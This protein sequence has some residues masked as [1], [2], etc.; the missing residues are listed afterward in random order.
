MGR[1]RGRTALRALLNE[2]PSDKRVLQQRALLAEME[3]ALAE[4]NTAQ[5]N[6]IAMKLAAIAKEIRAAEDEQRAAMSAAVDRALSLTD[7]AVRGAKL[8]E[9]FEICA[10]TEVVAHDDF[11]DD[12]TVARAIELKHAIVAALDAMPAGRAVLEALLD[13][14]FAGVRASAGAYRLNASL[15]RERIVPLLQEIERRVM[16]SAGWTAFWALSPND[17]GAWLD[18]DG[19]G[20]NTK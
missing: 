12:E 7:A 4:G 10:L 11:D 3:A 20:E 5:Q 2:G 6:E 13:S 19:A 15:L 18:L 16:S 1:D 8:V 9:A 17:H 14:P